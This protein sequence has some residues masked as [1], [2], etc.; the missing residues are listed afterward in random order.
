MF[1]NG[2]AAFVFD[3][4]HTA[5]PLEILVI[6][7]IYELFYAIEL[8]CRTVLT[9]IILPNPWFPWF[10]VILFLLSSVPSV[11]PLSV[12]QLAH[13]LD[14]YPICLPGPFPFGPVPSCLCPDWC[15]S[16]FFDFQLLSW[17]WRFEYKY[18]VSSNAH[19]QARW[20]NWPPAQPKSL[21]FPQIEAYFW[22]SRVKMPYPPN[23]RLEPVGTETF[24]ILYLRILM[25]WIIPFKRGL[26]RCLHDV[27]KPPRAI[28]PPPDESHCRTVVAQGLGN[29]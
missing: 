13:P 15:C 14:Q 18:T 29:P 7:R 1:S 21:Q 9:Q 11:N 2:I 23:M 17:F 10:Q 3:T 24:E 16:Y 19:I 25:H 22:V 20:Y 6:K 5:I 4:V 12:F 28:I 26:R 27:F 8:F